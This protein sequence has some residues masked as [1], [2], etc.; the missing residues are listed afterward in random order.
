M[1]EKATLSTLD[2]YLQDHRGQ[3]VENLKAAL[4]IPSVSSQSEHKA[5]VR[6]CAE[7][8]AAH[9]KQIGMTRAEVV[10][11]P[12]HPVVYAEW[13]GP[14]RPPRAPPPAHLHTQPAAR[15]AP[16]EKATP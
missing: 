3:F 12:G 9:L 1:S 11:T 7:H 2:S 10:T 5:D 14:P 15:P 8:I 16:A 6:R 4:R 13:L